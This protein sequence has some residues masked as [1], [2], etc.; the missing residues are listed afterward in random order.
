MPFKT[1]CLEF[2]VYICIYAYTHISTHIHTHIPEPLLPTK[3]PPGKPLFEAPKGRSWA[4]F[5]KVRNGGFFS[6]F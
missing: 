2:Q 1:G 3:E 5:D 6:G 4:D